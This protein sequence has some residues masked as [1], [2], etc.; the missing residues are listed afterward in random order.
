MNT[1][2]D[3]ALSR[4]L[5]D[6]SV[7]EKIIIVGVQL[8]GHDEDGV[9]ASLDELELLV[10]TAGADVVGRLVQRRDAPDHTW[11][12]GQGKAEELKQLCLAVDADTVV[13]D[14]EL[15]PAQ[16]YNLEK[17]LGR[18]AIDRTAVILDIF[19]Q[20]AHTLEGKAQV[21]LALLRYR[22]PRLRRGA[23]A[24]LSQQRGGVGARFGGGETKIETDR[25]RIMRRI[26]KLERDL[27]SLAETRSLQRLSLIHI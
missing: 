9:D 2:Y 7:R 19:G 12:I 1:P 27:A 16:Q 11:Y 17:L 26:N 25:R 10:D 23:K 14:N 8:H 3:E 24:K 13:F 21:E 15:S 6:R 5:I 4:T 20:N 18:T 22:R